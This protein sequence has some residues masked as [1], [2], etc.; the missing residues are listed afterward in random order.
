MH[1]KQTTSSI[2]I[3]L[4]DN[5]TGSVNIGHLTIFGY[6]RLATIEVFALS[7]SNG[8]MVLPVLSIKPHFPSFCTAAIP[9]KK[10]LTSEYITGVTNF[11][12][13]STNPILFHE[14]L[15]DHQNLFL[16]TYKPE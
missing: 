5:F 6:L 13:I 14:R 2:L 3:S 1:Q 11:P 4:P 9:F 8:I 12:S 15:K 10:P 16:H 7:Y